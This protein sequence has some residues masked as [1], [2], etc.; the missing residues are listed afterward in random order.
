MGVHSVFAICTEVIFCLAD[1]PPC[2]DA[3]VC[4]PLDQL[5]PAHHFDAWEYV[6]YIMTLSFLLEGELLDRQAG[7][8]QIPLTVL[9]GCQGFQ[10]QCEPFRSPVNADMSAPQTIKITPKPLQAIVRSHFPCQCLRTSGN[11]LSETQGFWT[12]VNFLTDMI[13]LAAF[14]LRVIGLIMDDNGQE[15]QYHFRSFQ[16]LSCVAPLIWVKLVNDSHPPQEVCCTYT[17][18]S[19]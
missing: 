11:D 1:D 13:L 18:G 16:V 2:P 4:S 6:L 3:L 10:G 5:D 17:D 12:V 7:I 9:R 15:Q 14:T 19:S 8:S